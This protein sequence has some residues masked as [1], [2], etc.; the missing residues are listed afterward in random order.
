MPSQANIVLTGLMGTGKSVVGQLVSQFVERPFVDTD[1]LIEERHGPI[2][3]IFDAQGEAHFR[4]VERE[5]VRELVDRGGMV[6]AT[7]GGTL[8]DEASAAMLVSLG[9]AVYTLTAAP[10]EIV[11]RVT[12][13]GVEGRPLLAGGDPAGRV[14]DLLRDR[15]RVYGRFTQVRTDGRTPD[16]IALEIANDARSRGVVS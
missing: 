3:A 9:S 15:E 4:R 2:P 13:D 8:V 6:I 1:A 14:T 10:A 5:V 12:A 7:G 11:R 16:A